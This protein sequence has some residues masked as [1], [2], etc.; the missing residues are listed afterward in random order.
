[1]ASIQQLMEKIKKGPIPKVVALAGSERALLMEALML[2]REKVVDK[3]T[4]DLN[5]QKLDLAK[6][7]FSECLCSLKSMPF[8]A[9][10]RLVEV[11]SIEKLSAKELA[12][13]KNYIEY[14]LE[15]S[16][17]VLLFEK[18]DKRNSVVTALNK[19]E[20]LYESNP[21]GPADILAFI[22]KQAELLSL[23]LTSQAMS[24]LQEI[25]DNDVCAITN[26]LEKLSLAKQKD[27]PI[28]LEDVLD[29]VANTSSPDAFLLVRAIA[30]GQLKKSL[31]VLTKLKESGE[32]PLKF[33]GLLQWQLRTIVSLRHFL[34]EGMSDIAAG[35]GAQIY[36]DRLYWMLKVAKHKNMA[37]HTNRLV[38]TLQA[39]AALKSVNSHYPYSYI[40]KLVYQSAVGFN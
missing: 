39:D 26:A 35:K 19:M 20:V 22:K 38:R 37:F 2:I 8:L 36:G 3:S 14:P 29:H 30:E 4:A 18:F 1:M 33:L 7:D 23:N 16:Y 28:T 25:L 21:L 11:G 9:S 40:E 24:M 5:H 34:D 10:H 17:L 32:N 6:A 31:T 12:E 27:R 13:L 15:S